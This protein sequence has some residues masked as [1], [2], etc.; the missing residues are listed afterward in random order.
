MRVVYYTDAAV[1]GGAE[2]SM[3]NLLAALSP[4]VEATV[5]GTNEGIVERVAAMRSGADAVVLP[6][7]GN[8]RAVSA[9]HAHRRAFTRLRPDIVQ[10]NI[11]VCGASPW[12]TA[13]ALATPGVRVIAVEHLPHAILSRR[14][15]VVTRLTSR[16][17]DA[18]VAVGERAADEIARFIGIPRSTLRVIRNGVAE[19]AIAN[20]PR[21]NT[22]PVVGSIGRLD[23]QKAYDV[24]VRALADLPGVTAV[25]VGEG[26]ERGRLEALAAEL[27]VS[28]RLELAGWIDDARSRLAA[29]DVFVLPSRFEGLPLVAIEA[30]LAG[31]PV[32]ATDVGSVSEAV[33]DGSTGLLVP[34]DDPAALARAIASLLAD[35]ALRLEM[36]QRG[37]HRALELFRLED[38]A[39]R[40]ETLYDEVLS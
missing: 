21:A 23:W 32:V 15:R 4:R 22:G 28:D 39:A 27:G 30:M 18:H 36:G 14:R 35:P 37:R 3:G 12:A 10:L 19:T 6:P 16:W 8:V 29:F 17:L 24:L 9:M 34:P 11:N 1:L 20:S 7:L 31:V 33:V 2:L 40:Y 26:E 25:I 38:M 13:A 5:V